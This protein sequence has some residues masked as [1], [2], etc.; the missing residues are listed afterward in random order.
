MSAFGPV[1]MT[2][3]EGT[4][5]GSTSIWSSVRDAP[6]SFR[7][8]SVPSLNPPA[9]L[10]IKQPLSPPFLFPRD[11]TVN[12]R[13]F[14]ETVFQLLK[15][16]T[17]LPPLNLQTSQNRLSS[18]NNFSFSCYELWLVTFCVVSELQDCKYGK[19]ILVFQLRINP[20]KYATGKEEK[21][22]FTLRKTQLQFLR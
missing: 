11:L 21:I 22:N 7:T 19:S 20:A 16:E 13:K 2:S 12:Y 9:F 1:F 8:C 17:S 18:R 4:W 10:V 15:W 14:H 3:S 5:S 6:S